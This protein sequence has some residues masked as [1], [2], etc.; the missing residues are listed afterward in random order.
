MGKSSGN[1]PDSGNGAPPRRGL[2]AR[3]FRRKAEDSDAFGQEPEAPADP[4]G[5]VDEAQDARFRRR[6]RLMAVAMLLLLVGGGGGAAAYFW[7]TP[8]GEEQP[9]AAA[10]PETTPSRGRRV[11]R[12]MP[13]AP[14]PENLRSALIRPPGS[15]PIDNPDVAR[16]MGTLSATPSGAPAAA[17]QAPG[18]AP[19][20]APAKPAAQAAPPA[21]M[22]AGPEMPSPR[23]D[24]NAAS[25][26]PRLA[27]LPKLPPPQQPLP[28]APLPELQQRT[29]GGLVLPAVAADG[30]HA[31]QAYGRPFTAQARIPRVAVIVRVG[32]A[33]EPTRAA[34]ESMPPEVTLAFDVDAPQ[35]RA[36]LAQARAAGHET[37]LELGM[38]AAA[39]PAVD[40]GPEGLLTALGEDKNRERLDR[41]LAR[42][43]VYV[44]LLAR[45]GERYAASPPHFA[46]LMQ[47]LARMG[48]AYVAS[49]RASPLETARMR[50]A[51]AAV[52]VAI[53]AGSF[54]ERVAAYIAHAETLARSRG[55]AV[56][57]ADAT[58]LNLS[59]LHAWFGAF[60]GK[61]LQLAPLSAVV[62]DQ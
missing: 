14:G 8:A 30:R 15:V 57:V 34:I 21:A 52:D 35:L 41:A 53:P 26:P 20:A 11:V 60:P 19:A 27:D 55:G 39:F 18:Q 56:V 4:F 13:P 51:H 50:P 22:A 7:L 40:P 58:P 42:G 45:D 43:D 38:E 9:A 16:R 46:A 6:K 24:R 61:A 48:I 54:R 5:L 31:W 36:G 29:A 12:S 1:G 37:M 49:G 28:K 59:M 44:G 3:L 17:P 32:L 23:A 33:A 47:D 10:A 2:F 62:K 25:K